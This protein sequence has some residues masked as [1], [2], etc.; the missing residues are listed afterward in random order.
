MN[1]ISLGASFRVKRKYEDSIA[2]IFKQFREH[3]T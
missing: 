2:E 1:F 3:N